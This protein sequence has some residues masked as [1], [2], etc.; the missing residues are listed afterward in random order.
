MS[1]SDACTYLFNFTPLAANLTAHFP[2]F[3]NNYLFYFSFHHITDFILFCFAKNERSSIGGCHVCRWNNEDV[4]LS[5]V[6]EWAWR[7]FW[8]QK[9]EL[10]LLQILP[11]F[12][13]RYNVPLLIIPWRY[14]QM[15]SSATCIGLASGRTSRQVVILKQGPT[16]LRMLHSEMTTKSWFKVCH[17]SFNICTTNGCTVPFYCSN[18]SFGLHL[19]NILLSFS[20]KSKTA[21][22]LPSW[23][24]LWVCCWNL[25]GFLSKL[26]A[27]YSP[28]HSPQ[29]CHKFT[30]LLNYSFQVWWSV[31]VHFLKVIISMKLSFSFRTASGLTDQSSSNP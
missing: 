23:S 2:F 27:L 18:D 3:G 11:L 1:V 12:W 14:P 19:D 22:I 9:W 30:Q 25:T 4:I 20:A 16:V 13:H 31:L 29:F 10:G 15:S 21:R 5:W 17:P 24:C 7:A 6:V 28:R 8:L 26:H